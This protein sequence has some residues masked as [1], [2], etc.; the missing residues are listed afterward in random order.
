[1]MWSKVIGDYPW[2]QLESFDGAELAVAFLKSATADSRFMS[3]S[4]KYKV[5]GTTSSSLAC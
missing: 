2:S 1:M 3:V 4:T 5:P